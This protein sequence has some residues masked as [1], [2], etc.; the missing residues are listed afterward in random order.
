MIKMGPFSLPFQWEERKHEE[1]D[2]GRYFI[3][4]KK[5]A[6]VMSQKRGERKWGNEQ[7]NSRECKEE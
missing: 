4:I 1:E 3:I 6:R 7:W 5:E 2:R